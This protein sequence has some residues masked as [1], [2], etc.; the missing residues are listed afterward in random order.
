MGVPIYGESLVVDEA[1][2]ED[3]FSQVPQSSMRVW[4]AGAHEAFLDNPVASIYRMSELN[5]LR[6]E[7][8]EDI[9][10]LILKK[11]FDG[12]YGQLGLQWDDRMTWASAKVLAARKTR[13]RQNQFI[14]SRGKG[15]VFEKVGLFGTS[16]V[17]SLMDPVN[18][19]MSFLP[20]VQAPRYA[21]LT[22]RT[23]GFLARFQSGIIKAP[24][25]VEKAMGGS[26]IA[27]I[28]IGLIEGAAGALLTE[29]VTYFARNQEQADYT[30]LDFLNNILIGSALGAGLHAGTG[31]ISDIFS[32]LGMKRINADLRSAEMAMRQMVDGKRVDV[33]PL[34]AMDDA[35]IT[36]ANNDFS[37]D[38]RQVETSLEMESLNLGSL[39]EVEITNRTKAGIE[40][41]FKGD[42]GHNLTGFGST[43]ERATDN[44]VAEF[45][46]LKT[47]IRNS[48][49]KGKTRELQSNLERLVTE[50]N[51]LRANLEGRSSSQSLQTI[52]KLQARLDSLNSPD[53]FQIKLR[54]LGFP[55]ETRDQIRT[56]ID[57][58]EQQ[59]SE[60]FG[61]GRG[62]KKLPKLDEEVAALEFQFR[63]FIKRNDEGKFAKSREL[64]R[65][66]KSTL[67]KQIKGAE[68][69]FDRNRI[70]ARLK[71]VEKQIESMRK[72]IEDNAVNLVQDYKSKNLSQETDLF[73]SRPRDPEVLEKLDR[74]VKSDIEEAETALRDVEELLEA[75]LQEG[76]PSNLRKQIDDTV[77]LGKLVETMSKAQTTGIECMAGLIDG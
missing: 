65:R 64:L 75:E 27:R 8:G 55:T 31:K 12:L 24:N 49:I 59:R 37:L 34:R 5:N 4:G 20:V 44:L 43:V 56:K 42:F 41:R 62:K 28:Q 26:T 22:Q 2:Y 1:L 74:P 17:A 30:A 48:A 58:L 39:P 57:A 23:G 53:A 29:P 7:E 6:A 14:M 69:K 67:R 32:D 47:D 21:R 60:I 45:R 18:I 77:E 52:D 40:V 66:E 76:L 63:D 71:K 3:N 72:Q 61:K 70:S 54:E 10:D 50:R 46:R 19:A 15:T 38:G 9:G 25:L 35:E 68:L 33:S 11:Q 36:I 73:P 51:L 16:L 13:E